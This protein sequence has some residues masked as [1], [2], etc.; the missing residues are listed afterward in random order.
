MRGSATVFD[1]PLSTS[2]HVQKA[3]EARGHRDEHSSKL[4]RGLKPCG[5]SAV[6]LA[7]P[8]ASA[9][10]WLTCGGFRLSAQ[11]CGLSLP[12]ACRSARTSDSPSFTA[13]LTFP[14]RTRQEGRFSRGKVAVIHRAGLRAFAPDVGLLSAGRVP[15]RPLKRRGFPGDERERYLGEERPRSYVYLLYS[16]YPSHPWSA[17]QSS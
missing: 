10:G 17:H 7:D 4:P 1:L 3:G 6:R 12:A 15:P 9:S 11:P 5:F 16:W 13:G 2:Y 14:Q 8:T